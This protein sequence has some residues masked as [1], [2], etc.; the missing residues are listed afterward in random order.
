MEGKDRR[1]HTCEQYDKIESIVNNVD[2]LKNEYHELRTRIKDMNV[3]L[4]RIDERLANKLE[5]FDDHIKNGNSFRSGL[6]FTAI[7]LIVSVVGAVIGYGK[8]EQKV[9]FI[10]QH[11]YGVRDTINLK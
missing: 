7:G 5:N 3:M 2:E 4:T 11:S 10:W 9:E 8:L 6:I 1:A